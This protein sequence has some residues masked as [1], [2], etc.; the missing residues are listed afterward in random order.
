[1]YWNLSRDE[2]EPIATTGVPGH[3]QEYETSMALAMFPENVR[4]DAMN[5]QEDKL[6]LE[7][8]AEKGKLLVQLAVAKTA[9]YLQGMIDGGNDE[10][11][12][13]LMSWQLDPKAN[14]TDVKE[15]VV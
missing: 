6:P 9:E 8:N 7:A 4:R 10:I 14:E 12:P 2:A 13:H 11:R 3:A 15:R 1:S 5:D